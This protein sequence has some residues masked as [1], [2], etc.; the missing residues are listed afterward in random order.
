MCISKFSFQDKK[1]K[2]ILLD[3][4]TIHLFAYLFMYFY[5][6]AIICS[7]LNKKHNN[8]CLLAEILWKEHKNLKTFGVFKFWWLSHNIRTL[9]ANRHRNTY[10]GIQINAKEVDSSKNYVKK[11][12]V[13]CKFFIEAN[14]MFSMYQKWI[15]MSC[16]KKI[17]TLVR[18]TKM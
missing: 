10:L 17:Y 18:G 6:S 1:N 15:A 7:R 4:F 14:N 5:K 2:I 8:H 9:Q 11:K 3:Q 12:P 13:K 16:F